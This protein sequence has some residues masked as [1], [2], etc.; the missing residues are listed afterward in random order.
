MT[1]LSPTTST[2]T[3]PRTPRQPVMLPITFRDL[4]IPSASEPGTKHAVRLFSH[5]GALCDCRAYVFRGRCSHIAQAWKLAPRARC[6]TPGCGRV[7]LYEDASLDVRLHC[8]S[9][10]DAAERGC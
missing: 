2:Q 6:V 3:S 7:Y 9:H 10:R 5:G 1:T 4:A 8:P